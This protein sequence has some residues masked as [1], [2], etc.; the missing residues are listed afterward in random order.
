MVA[1]V[2][3]LARTG[4]GDW[5]V[6]RLTALVLAAYTLFMLAW[7]LL[8]APFDYEQ[9]SALFG[10][11]WMRAFSLLALL[12]VCA[13]AW[14]GLWTLSGDYLNERALGRCAL[15]IRF[16]FQMFCGALLFG[17]GVWGIQILWEL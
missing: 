3:S 11:T 16:L 7:L 15:V 13:H 14:I 4:L 9:W 12:S 6:Q 1:P 8:H 17:Y 10:Q 5:M 2:T